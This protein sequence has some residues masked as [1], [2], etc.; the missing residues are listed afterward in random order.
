LAALALQTLY[1]GALSPEQLLALRP[2]DL[3]A[4]A[5]DPSTLA[6]LGQL[7]SQAAS[8]HPLFT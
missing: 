4:L 6:S 1:S 8:D 7:A 3:E 2:R 5:V